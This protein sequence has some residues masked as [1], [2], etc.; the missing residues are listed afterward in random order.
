MSTPKQTKKEALELID[1]LFG[2]TSVSKR[3]TLDLL[4]DIQSEVDSKIDA[5]RADIKA[6]EGE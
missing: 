5:L 2:D 3:Q 1:Q 4:E 6:E